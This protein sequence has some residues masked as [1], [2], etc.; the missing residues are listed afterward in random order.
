MKKI[1]PGVAVRPLGY[2]FCIGGLI[3]CVTMFWQ[4]VQNPPLGAPVDSQEEF[5]H[6]Q[7]VIVK[8]FSGRAGLEDIASHPQPY[9]R[10]R[11]YLIYG[12]TKGAL[13]T[14][15]GIGLLSRRRWGWWVAQGALVLLFA[16]VV[17]SVLVLHARGVA[18]LVLVEHR[19][20][21]MIGCPF[22]IFWLSYPPVRGV[23]Y[24]PTVQ[25]ASPPRSQ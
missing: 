6:L 2:L 12:A 1:R 23:F 8:L 21:L 24:A 5:A 10:L 16:G 9:E 19:I 18:W 4:L 13:L 14:F 3:L 25:E 17:G 15:L 20:A 7:A 11:Q 22:L